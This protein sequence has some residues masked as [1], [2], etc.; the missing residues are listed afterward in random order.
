MKAIADANSANK[1]RLTLVCLVFAAASAAFI[2]L[3]K[4]QC[5]PCAAA[6]NLAPIPHLELIGIAFYSLLALAIWRYKLN[7][8]TIPAVYFAAGCHFALIYELVKAQVFCIP[9][10]ICG[11]FV[12]IAAALL[13]RSFNRLAWIAAFCG[14]LTIYGAHSISKTIAIHKMEERTKIAIH[15]DK[16]DLKS[17]KGLPLYVFKRETCGHCR[18]FLDQDLPKLR[19]MYGNRLIIHL[20]EAAPTVGVPTIVVG[21]NNPVIRVGK[22]GWE[23]VAKL[24]DGR[25]DDSGEDLASAYSL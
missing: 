3:A 15:F 9:C 2:N 11:L 24:I 22:T 8:Y 5:T 10:L 6:E 20:V 1:W 23:D 16:L 17:K 13:I 4:S 21:G 7:R 18:E 25:L 12:A 19:T 14:G